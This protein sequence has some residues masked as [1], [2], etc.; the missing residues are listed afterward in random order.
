MDSLYNQ[1]PLL[2]SMHRLLIEKP[3]LLDNLHSKDIIQAYIYYR[4]FKK[5]VEKNFLRKKL[6]NSVRDDKNNLI[7]KCKICELVEFT[8]KDNYFSQL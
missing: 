7:N 8:A 1:P 2:D 3:T 5:T 4:V 6:E